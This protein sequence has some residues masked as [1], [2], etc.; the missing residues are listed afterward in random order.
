MERK[1]P[2]EKREGPIGRGERTDAARPI[3]QER[4]KRDRDV[5][6]SPLIPSEITP[7]DLDLG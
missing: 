1:R 4:V 3:W 2:S 5:E 6:K 7:E